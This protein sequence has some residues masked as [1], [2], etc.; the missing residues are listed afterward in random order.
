VSDAA[1]AS[2][3]AARKIVFV[4]FGQSR[5]VF[6]R[7]ELLVFHTSS[8]EGGEEGRE[9]LIENATASSSTRF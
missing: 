6:D 9:K 2:P 4:L 1:V 8:G 3:E 5:F 7:D